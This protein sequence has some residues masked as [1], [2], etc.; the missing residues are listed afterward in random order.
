MERTVCG[1]ED[2]DDNVGGC[3]PHTT[4]PLLDDDAADDD[5]DY[6]YC[7]LIKLLWTCFYASI[8][9]RTLWPG[10]IHTRP[11]RP[12]YTFLDGGGMVVPVFVHRIRQVPI[13]DRPE[14]R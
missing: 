3:R 14:K 11:V 2:E 4:H 1:K 13:S 9:S 12:S 7:R 5:N 6:P 8:D 10:H